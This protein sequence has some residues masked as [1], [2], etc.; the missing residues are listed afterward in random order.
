MIIDKNPSYIEL[1]NR[2]LNTTVM[3]EA[4]NSANLTKV[5]SSDKPIVYGATLNFPP[6]S[7]TMKNFFDL[8]AENFGVGE[9]STA[10]NMQQ[11]DSTVY[12]T[13]TFREFVSYALIELDKHL[14][15][16]YYLC[17]LSIIELVE[18]S[19]RFAIESCDNISQTQLNSLAE[20][21]K[22]RMESGDV[23]ISKCFKGYLYSVE[24]YGAHIIVDDKANSHLFTLE[25]LDSDKKLY[26]LFPA[27]SDPILIP[28]HGQTFH[29]AFQ[30]LQRF[31]HGGKPSD[32][33]ST[34]F[35]SK[36]G[37]ENDLY[38]DIVS[39]LFK[40]GVPPIPELMKDL[41]CNIAVPFVFDLLL[42]SPDGLPSANFSI[43]IDF[44]V[45]YYGSDFLPSVVNCICLYDKSV[46]PDEHNNPHVSI[47][48]DMFDALIKRGV[49]LCP[50][51]DT[52]SNLRSI[53]VD[54]DHVNNLIA[55][56]LAETLIG[57]IDDITFNP[58]EDD[59][60]YSLSLSI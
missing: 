40:N 43:G 19:A 45:K 33:L 2:M 48:D 13:E 1:A 14:N 20:F 21:T 38:D 53:F 35:V 56:N 12:G 6:A 47:H 17:Y 55:N 8:P 42:R 50:V 44:L 57:C 60:D 23:S 54:I 22:E 16:S 46:L 31:S 29:H 11:H 7:E 32:L 36:V 15:E 41:G 28:T 59:F 51:L 4:F 30:F 39:S 18:R 5:P 49:N 25:Y 34:S 37:N 24:R 3:A 26:V 9:S 52:I 27:L 58:K 10:L